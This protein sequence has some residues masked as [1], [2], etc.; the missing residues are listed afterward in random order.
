MISIRGDQAHQ[1]IAVRGMGEAGGLE[2]G[3]CL[4]RLA[5][6]VQGNRIDVGVSRYVGCQVRRAL[7]LD[8]AISTLYSTNEK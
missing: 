8:Q 7:Q 4:R 1:D 5:G 3:Q 2:H 6:A